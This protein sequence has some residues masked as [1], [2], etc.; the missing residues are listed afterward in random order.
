V[1]Q[2]LTL[3]AQSRH[4]HGEAAAGAVLA[5]QFLRGEEGAAR[6]AGDEMQTQSLLFGEETVTRETAVAQHEVAPCGVG[7]LGGGERDLTGGARRQLAVEAHAVEHVVEHREAALRV[8]HAGGA[9]L[10]GR[11]DHGKLGVHARVGGQPHERAV[12]AEHAVPAP[13]LDGPRGRRAVDGGQYALAVQLDESGVAELGAGVRA[14]AG[15]GRL[16]RV[17]LG[18]LGEKCAHMPLERLDGFL[19]HEEHDEWERQP[20]PPGEVSR[21]HAVP[22]PES[23]VG[24]APTQR[25]EQGR[26]RRGHRYMHDVPA[27]QPPSQPDR[28]RA[29]I[30]PWP[31]GLTQWQWGVALGCHIFAPVGLPSPSV[32]PLKTARNHYFG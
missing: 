19:Q 27:S 32:T 5:K 15:R 23:L 31:T 1:G 21:P 24:Q 20:A 9:A 10:V 8:A 30:R 25:C 28:P 11:G 6:T 4:L 7:E 14:G 16:G 26:H 12:D 18:Q 29:A 17:A 13:A 3:R 22:R 2:A